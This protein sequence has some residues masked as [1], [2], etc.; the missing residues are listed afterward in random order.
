MKLLVVTDAWEPQVNGV[1]RTLK[2]TCHKLQTWG[3][4]VEMLTPLG[5]KSIPCPTYK[6]ISLTLSPFKHIS[7]NMEMFNADAIHIATEGPLGWAARRYCKL[8]GL[9]FTTSFHTRFPEY[10]HARAK[11]PTHWTYKL[12]RRFHSLARSVMVTTPSMKTK[13]N[14]HGF[15]NLQHWSRGV[16]TDLFR[17]QSRSLS[18]NKPKLLYV[19]RVA[20]EKNLEAFLEMDIDSIKIVVGD[21][22]QLQQL[23]LR[24]PEVIF[25]GAKFGDELVSY[26]AQ[27]DAFVF[28]SRTDTFGL[29]M[30]EALAC[31]TPVAAFPTEGPLDVIQSREVGCLD[32]D[33]KKATMRALGK[34]RSKCRRY[35]EQFSWDHCTKQFLDHLVLV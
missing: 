33:L 10:I 15:K 2:T 27:A 29:V 11:I 35:A 8:R 16:D 13:L 9:S 5:G 26:Y 4:E 6:E 32:R 19:G 24:Y 23:K 28:P 21:G 7:Q 1:V 34:S 22:P 20:V 17:P 3:H 30:L 18:S 14:E 25:T 12:L 31:G